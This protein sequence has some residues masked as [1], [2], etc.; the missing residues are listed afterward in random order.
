MMADIL[1]PEQRHKCMASIKSEN[2]KPEMIVRKFLFSHGFRYRLHDRNLP[3]KPDIV[4][5]KYKALIFVD[6]CFW[7]CHENCSSSKIPQSRQ[8]YWINK[9]KKN[10]KRDFE[11][12]K[13]LIQQGL[14]VFR[15]WECTLKN[16]LSREEVLSALINNIIHQK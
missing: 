3:G 8:E 5:K 11:I 7:H 9:L 13:I 12:N 14:R 10:K 6:G 2:T 4:L 1:T 16:K 15:I